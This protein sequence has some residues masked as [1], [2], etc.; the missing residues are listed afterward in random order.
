MKAIAFNVPCPECGHRSRT[1]VE[2][3]TPLT[4]ED[5]AYAAWRAGICAQCGHSP[6]LPE[7]LQGTLTMSTRLDPPNQPLAGQETQT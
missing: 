5:L 6:S 3:E 2:S 1:T 7:C 4:T